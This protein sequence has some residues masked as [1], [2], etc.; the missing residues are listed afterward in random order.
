MKAP[1][2]SEQQVAPSGFVPA[3]QTCAWHDDED[4]T[5]HT[6]CGGEWQC[7]DGSPPANGMKFCPFCGK[8][9]FWHEFKYPEDADDE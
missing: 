9:L 4:G 2:T 1:V 6:A 5:S 7:E 8:Q 3:E